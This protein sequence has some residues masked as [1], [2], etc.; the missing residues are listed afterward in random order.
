MKIDAASDSYGSWSTGG[1]NGRVS[2][3]KIELVPGTDGTLVTEDSATGLASADSR[4]SVALNALAE[5][6]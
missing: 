3:S 1:G 2:A 5:A 4:G 6:G